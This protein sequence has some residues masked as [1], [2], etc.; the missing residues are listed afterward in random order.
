MGNIYAIQYGPILQLGPVLNHVLL[1]TNI[2]H[3]AN[4]VVIGIT[5]GC[6]YL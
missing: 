2:C 1:T 6:Q 3:D 5:Q 4:F